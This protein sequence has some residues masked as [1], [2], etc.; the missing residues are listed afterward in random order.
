MEGL[1]STFH[2]DIKL[3]AAQLVNFSIVL[4][5]LYKFAYKPLLEKMNERTETIEKG[6]EDAKKAQARLEES[7]KEKEQIVLKARRE[8]K[9]ILEDAHRIG[10]KNR[11]EVIAKTKEE[12]K[13]VVE[14]A[15]AQI[16]AEKSKMLREVKQEVG[17]L[18]ALA[19]EKILG[20]KMSDKKDKEMIEN[21]IGEITEVKS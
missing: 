14:D 10:E 5:V 18:V 19:T 21:V 13:K 12:A 3:I 2:L 4:L 6:L 9:A 8:A 20:E 1:I 17:N 11:D 16:S 7:Q 15:K